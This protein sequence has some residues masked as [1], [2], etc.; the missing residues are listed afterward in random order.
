MKAISLKQPFTNYIAEGKK[1]LETRTWSTKYRGPILIVSSLSPKIEPIGQALAVAT[2]VNCR[3]MLKSDEKAA[4]CELYE[5]AIAWELTDIH[6][7][8]PFPVKGSL[9]IYNIDVEEIEIIS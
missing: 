3:P 8:K 7:I 6:R 1:T 4:C 2:I 9:S 5:R